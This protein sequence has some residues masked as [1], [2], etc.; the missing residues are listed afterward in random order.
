MGTQFSMMVFTVLWGVPYLV[1]GQGLSPA[2]AGGLVTLFVVCAIVIGPVIGVLTGR[3]P[4]RRSWLVLGI[5][6]ADVA[7]WSAVLAW[8]GPAPHGLLVMLVVVLAAGGP[9]SVIGFD[10]ARTSNP[11]PNLGLAQSIVNLGGFLASLLVLAAMGAIL[12]GLG[13]FTPGAFRVAWLVQYPVWAFAVV[14]I[15][16]ARRKARRI[17]AARGVVPRPIREVLLAGARR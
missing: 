4:L 17:D 1:S 7:A 9:G 16:V 5:V 3:H 6:A 12:S 2:E 15:V 8:P 11:A 10:I 13:G 14:G